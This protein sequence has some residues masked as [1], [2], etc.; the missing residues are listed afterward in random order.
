MRLTVEQIIDRCGTAKV[1]PAARIVSAS[2]GAITTD[3]V[4]KWRNNGIPEW[5][6]KL[7]KR[8]AGVD[9]KTLHRAN[10][11]IR[12]STPLEAAE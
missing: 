7:I 6:W 1:K 9:E 3:A 11:R 2:D 8:L 4:Y 10:E 12:A 5:H